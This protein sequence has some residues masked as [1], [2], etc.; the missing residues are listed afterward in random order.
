MRRAAV[1]LILIWY[2]ASSL[3]GKP[4]LP[5]P[6]AVLITCFHQFV[7]GDLLTHT[8]VSLG[9]ILLALLSAFIPAAVLGI[10]AGRFKRF[11][12]VF[13]PFV[14]LL[15][16]IPKIAFLPIILLFFGLGDLSKI[17]LIM[18]II[19]FQ[20]FVV[21]RDAVAAISPAYIDSFMTLS[22]KRSDILRHVILPAAAPKIFTAI[23][24]AL[25]TSFAVLFIA[26]TFATTEGLGWYI[27][28]SWSRLDYLGLYAGITALS[29]LGT[30]LFLLCDHAARRIS[31]W[32][33]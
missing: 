3:L 9:R 20:L 10:A 29:L 13:S 23:R 14:Y 6:H 1:L 11:D 15:Y 27:M 7:Q 21:I 18:L 31:P 30:L 4:F 24:I 32:A 25:G 8:A 19:F 28:D 33:L 16:P 17:I 2:G 5:L 22:R 12:A 26:E